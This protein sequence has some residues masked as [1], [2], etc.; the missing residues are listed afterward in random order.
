MNFQR[1]KD[2]LQQFKKWITNPCTW[3]A[4]DMEQIFGTPG[5]Y[6]KRKGCC[7]TY[8]MASPGPWKL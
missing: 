3:G 8:S 6:C 1:V 5:M 2:K 4:H 7:K